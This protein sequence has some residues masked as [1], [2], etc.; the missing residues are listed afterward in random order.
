VTNEAP[1]TAVE[2]AVLEAFARVMGQSAPRGAETEPS[3]VGTW[4]SLTHIH[5]IAEI[6]GAL[7]VELPQSLLVNRGPLSEIVQAASAGER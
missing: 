7:D 3:D 5:L 1:A 4:T 6:E 2:T